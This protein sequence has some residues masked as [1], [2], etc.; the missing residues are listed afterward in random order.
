MKDLDDSTTCHLVED[1]EETL[2][3]LGNSG[4]E[5]LSIPTL[6]EQN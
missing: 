6:M 3:P 5:I 4:I 2:N 1:L